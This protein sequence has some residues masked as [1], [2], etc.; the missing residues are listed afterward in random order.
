MATV[1]VI[2]EVS[3]Y[4]VAVPGS[5]GKPATVQ[6]HDGNGDK[7]IATVYPVPGIRG[8]PVGGHGRRQRRHDSRPF[9]G[10]GPGVDSEVVV[11]N[12]SDTP[13]GPFRTELTRFAPFDAGLPGGVNVAGADIDGN[14][15]ADNIIVGSGPGMESQV[16]VFS[17]QAV[18]RE[19]QG[20][21]RVLQLHALPR[22]AGGRDVA[23]GLVEMDRAERAS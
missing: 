14:A 22:I 6:V 17:S 20:T 12:G 16:K 15:L 13:D 7:V 21:R 19:G 18:D 23:T 9:V 4:A 11:Y 1:N 5:N 8:H 3:T 10:T 2:P